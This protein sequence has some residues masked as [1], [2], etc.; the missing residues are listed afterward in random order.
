MRQHTEVAKKFY[1]SKA[2]K[3]C[4]AS[5]ISTVYGMCEHC[6]APGYIVDHI[7]EINSENINDPNITLNH[8]NLQ[9]LC[10][11]CHNKKTFTKYGVT[12]D[13]VMFDSN[14]DLIQKKTF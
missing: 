4:R 1:H 9:Y 5:Y 6:D 2:W 10:T 8:E 14:G 11:S 13:D 7:V 3:D 12:R